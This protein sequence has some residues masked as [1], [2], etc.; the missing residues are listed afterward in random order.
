MNRAVRVETDAYNQTRLSVTLYTEQQAA[1]LEIRGAFISLQLL[2]AGLN[3]IGQTSA[4]SLFD[5]RHGI[6]FRVP[7]P[8]LQRRDFMPAR[9]FSAVNGMLLMLTPTAS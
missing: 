9:T 6:D 2:S 8:A 5:V 7:V 3:R 4:V 1:S